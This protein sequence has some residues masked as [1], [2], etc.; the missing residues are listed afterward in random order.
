MLA[1]T[2]TLTEMFRKKDRER[3]LAREVIRLRNANAALAE[4]LLG[5]RR[6]LESVAALDV[7]RPAFRALRAPVSSYDSS[8][9]S[10]SITVRAGSSDAVAPGMAVTAD[11]ALIGVV[12]EVGPRQSRVRLITDAGSAIPC[13]AGDMRAL[14]ILQGTGG[15]TCILDWV[16]RDAFVEPG[17]IAVTAAAGVDPESRLKVPPGLPAA[18]VLRVE[19]DEMR[20]LFL[21]VEAVPRVNL[22]R[23]EGAEILIP[24]E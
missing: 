5:E 22:N 7:K 3:A 16:D 18:T 20:L 19:R 1:A 8:A 17:D 13:R 11:G 15:D 23:L 4:Q 24:L 10:R 12:T 9:M 6:I 21:S 14:C 2:G